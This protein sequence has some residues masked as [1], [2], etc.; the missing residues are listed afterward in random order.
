MS[1]AQIKVAIENFIENEERDF[2]L[3]KGFWGSGKTYFWNDIVSNASSKGKIGHRNYVYISLFGID[4][5]EMLKNSIIAA[6]INSSVVGKNSSMSASNLFSQLKTIA[7]HIEKI[8]K[9]RAYTEGWASEIAFQTVNNSLICFDDLERRSDKI[10]I[11]DILG[12]ASLLKEQRNCKIVFIS[13]NE[14]I[15][16]NGKEIFNQHSEKLIDIELSF[17]PIPEEAFGFIFQETDSFYSLLKICCL[18]LKIKNLRILQRINR[19][20]KYLSKFLDEFEESVQKE[21]I[22]SAVLFIWS[23]YSRDENTISLGTL[24][25]L[26]A[27][28]F[29]MKK[30]SNPDAVNKEDEKLIDFLSDYGW[31]SL[32]EI[33]K[34]LILYIEK[35]YLDENAFLFS[36]AKKNK[37]VKLRKGGSNYSKTWRLY[38]NSFEDNEA[39]FTENLIAQFNENIEALDTNDL[40]GA[41][42]IL[43]QLKKDNQANNL[44][45]IYIEF[46]KNNFTQN[47][48]ETIFFSRLND[49]YIR[50]KINQLNRKSRTEFSTE[51]VILRI[52]KKENDYEDIKFLASRDV[53]EFY[54]V[55]KSESSIEKYYLIQT[56]LQFEGGTEP[57]FKEVTTKAKEALKL[58]ALESDFNKIR[59]ENIYKINVDEFFSSA[60]DNEK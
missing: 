29:Y 48:L 37:E 36:L 15:L 54:N 33:D 21:V 35:G 56:C 39:E 60:K 34:S 30:Y 4:S 13:N 19:I 44:V 24:K 7:R 52:F 50:E 8:P 1:L 59:I 42:G 53:S 40:D 9:I 2:L 12:L 51:K 17:S 22:Q 57:F 26:S 46:H 11:K 32:S 28:G 25:E 49:S 14:K 3:I 18:K 58:I 20:A 5:F 41:V 38:D 45:D 55:F 6:Q 23:Y 16:D 47:F 10:D 27:F 31:S 43:R